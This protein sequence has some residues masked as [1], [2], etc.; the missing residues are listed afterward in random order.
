MA[1]S[2]MIDIF[3]ALIVP[4]DVVCLGD[5]FDIICAFV[6]WVLW[7]PM[8]LLNAWELIGFG[9]LAALDY[10]PTMTLIGLTQRGAS[11]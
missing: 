3:D 9:P 11:Q 5:L 2:V 1:I 7:G 10:I 4:L 8:G 6:G